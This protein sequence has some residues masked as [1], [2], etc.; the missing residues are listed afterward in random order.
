[1]TT[2]Q[3][4]QAVKSGRSAL[5]RYDKKW[6]LPEPFA[7]SLFT[8][9]QTA[10]MAISGYTCFESL[11]IHSVRDAL[12]EVKG[13][14][15]EDKR[16][17]FILST[18]KGNVD[19]LSYSS[20]DESCL[21]PASSAKKIA[22]V[23]GITTEPI[24][25]CN[26]CISGAAAQMLALRLLDAG[27]YDYAIVT[28]A[29]V[30]SAFIV[31]GFQSLKAVSDAPCRPFDIERIGLNLGEAAATIIFSSADNKGVIHDTFYEAD[32]S[33]NWALISASVRNDGFHITGPSPM[34]DGCYNAISD[35]MRGQDKGRLATVNV[36]GTAT[37]YNDQM[38]SVGISRA[39]LTD[40]PLSALKGYYGHTM[41]AAGVLETIITMRS[42]D[43]GLILPSLGFSEK[44]VSGK[45]LI[46]NKPIT[47]DK[48]SFL[49]II[50]GFGGCNAA[51]LFSK[52]KPKSLGLSV[53]S[54]GFSL[55]TTHTVDITS[56]E[57][58]VD[59]IPV[60]VSSSGKELLTSLYKSHIADYPKFYKMD[61]LTR[62]AFVASELLVQAEGRSDYDECASEIS[63]SVIL[64]NNSSSIVADRQYVSTIQSPNNFFPSPSVFVYTLPNITTGEIAI[65]NHYRGET[66]FYILPE[67]NEALINDIILSSVQ[68]S[69]SA[70]FISGWIDCPDEYN[71]EAHL[72]IY[73]MDS[74]FCESV[75]QAE[76]LTINH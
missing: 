33:T 11:V 23:I 44:G 37:M 45:V 13:L 61:M 5:S 72:K 42:L 63:R 19:M 53:E 76:Q 70:S 52:V 67:R 48:S 29:E 34:A 16:I 4:Y 14:N 18:T 73:Q 54:S 50:S 2:E 12:R 75:G 21:S 59:N 43:D 3:N 46:S 35:V 9:D 28:G 40:V 57:V 7:A 10:D 49:K 62:L 66:S 32:D 74:S 68:S 71:F 8:D 64:F 25:V 6:N 31:S 38:E 36:H 17:V 1:M 56:S 20:V 47:T 65:R 60:K 69:T 27:F 55:R 39:G 30:Q 58:L 15:I 24:V 41:G 26:A 51:L 22:A